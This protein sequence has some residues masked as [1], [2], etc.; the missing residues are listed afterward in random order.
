MSHIEDYL[1]EGVVI[2]KDGDKDAFEK[3]EELVG[4]WER[5]KFPD[6]PKMHKSVRNSNDRLKFICHLNSASVI[7]SDRVCTFK[8]IAA[9]K[10]GAETA[11]I[12]KN[13]CLEHSC[14]AADFEGQ[15]GGA[16][17][18]LTLKPHEGESAY[19][20]GKKRKLDQQQDNY[21]E[22]WKLINNQKM[23]V[24]DSFQEKCAY[25]EEIGIYE[26]SELKDLES[27]HIETLAAL[28]K[29]VPRKKW[30]RLFATKS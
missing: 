20:I 9:T 19:L 11:V 4:E 30:T 23:F 2:E 21:K 22:A 17:G 26:A 6:M 5:E 29:E 14:Q 8:L 25:F 28:L 15:K 24:A 3:I 12:S 27:D 10:D 16:T 13:V 7:E 18:K 1:V